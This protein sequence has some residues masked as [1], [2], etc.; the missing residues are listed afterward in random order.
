[1][2][3]NFSKEGYVVV[4]IKVCFWIIKIFCLVIKNVNLEVLKLECF[5]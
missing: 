3:F 4:L 2:L 5:I 1:M